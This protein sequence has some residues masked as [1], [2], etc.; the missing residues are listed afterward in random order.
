[1]RISNFSESDVGI[2]TCIASNM[3]GR[4]N[5]TIRLYGKCLASWQFFFYRLS[6]FFSFSSDFLARFTL[7]SFFSVS[8]KQFTADYLIIILYYSNEGGQKGWKISENKNVNRSVEFNCFC[9]SIEGF[10]TLFRARSFNLTWRFPRR[11][12]NFIDFCHGTF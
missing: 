3:M 11:E 4:A 7:C 2:Y 9:F 5:A 10:V 6:F 8:S 1:M 12:S